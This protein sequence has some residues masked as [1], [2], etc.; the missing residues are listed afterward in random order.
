[1]LCLLNKLNSD[2]K[3]TKIC[4]VLDISDVNFNQY[5]NITVQ[6]TINEFLKNTKIDDIDIPSNGNTFK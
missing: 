1:M 2:H 5:V 6:N 3:N 4:L